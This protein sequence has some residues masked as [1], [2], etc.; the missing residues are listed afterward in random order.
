M[1][2]SNS[3]PMPT[4]R[5]HAADMT[6]AAS[7]N[8]AA[9]ESRSQKGS[10]DAIMAGYLFLLPWFLGFFGLTSGPRSARSISPSPISIS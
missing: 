2:P 6:I 7:V 5:S 10:P 9:R 8:G 1:P 4:P 3:S